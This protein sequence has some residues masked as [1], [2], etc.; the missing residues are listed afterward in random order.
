MP[1]PFL[2]VV[3]EDQTVPYPVSMARLEATL[4]RLGHT[5]ADVHLTEEGG[6]FDLRG[7]TFRVSPFSNGDYTSIR[8][9]WHPLSPVALNYLFTAA[10]SWNRSRHF[11]TV[12]IDRS[13]Q[14]E[15]I[16]VADSILHCRYGLSDK[17]LEDEV[18]TAIIT[19]TK[20][21]DY[22]EWAAGEMH[23]RG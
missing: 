4:A 14:N 16:I 6:T 8:L 10:N 20:A 11:P 13:S 17:Q 22:V 18:E 12:Y 21:L 15:L 7:R 3:P 5:D 9:E 1:E 19:G 2:H 23:A